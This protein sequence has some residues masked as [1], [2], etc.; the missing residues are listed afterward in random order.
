[1]AFYRRRLPHW[2]PADKA[3]FINWRL[4]GS[5]P[6]GRAF[7]LGQKESFVA[8]DRLLDGMTTGPLYLR[9]PEIAELV[10]QEIQRLDAVRVAAWVV[11]PNHVHCSPILRI[12]PTKSGR[13]AS[14]LSKAAPL[15]KPISSPAARASVFGR[16]SP[17]IIGCAPPPSLPRSKAISSAT[18]SPLA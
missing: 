10:A 15:A 1:M 14:R 9:M 12:P 17:T 3:L 5:L 2:H 18:P 13:A 16:K 6:N 7:P 4:Y 11:M 8:F